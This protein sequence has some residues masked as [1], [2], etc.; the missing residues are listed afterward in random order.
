MN[1]GESS[2]KR[3]RIKH[4]CEKN[5]EEKKEKEEFKREEDKNNANLLAILFIFI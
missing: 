1:I 3:K 5:R 2:R 4:N